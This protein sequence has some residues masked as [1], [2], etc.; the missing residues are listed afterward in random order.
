[1]HFVERG[2]APEKLAEYRDKYT[3]K[4]IDCYG[5]GKGK[6]GKK[7][8]DDYWT[9]DEIRQPLVRAFEDNCGYC[10]RGTGTRKSKADGKQLPVGQVDHFLAKWARP[11][12]VYDWENYIWSCTD[13]NGVKSSYYDPECLLFDPCNADDMQYLEIHSDGRYYLKLQFGSDSLLKARY[14][15]TLV[16]TLMNSASRPQERSARK[17]ELESAMKSIETY[18][19]LCCSQEFEEYPPKIKTL[20]QKQFEEAKENLGE[21]LK[22]PSFK[23][24]IRHIVEEFLAENPKSRTA[25]LI[26][27]IRG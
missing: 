23:K 21:I 20:I 19:G 4:W 6:T 14:N 12:L 18:Y 1:M 24:M 9:E 8:S 25:D 17:H 2:A 7:P 16:N 5:K 11:E 15:A 27:E 3:Q 26:R 22:F 10:G 13:C